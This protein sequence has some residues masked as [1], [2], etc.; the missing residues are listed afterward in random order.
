MNTIRSVL[1]S[2]TKYKEE[3]QKCSAIAKNNVAADKN[4]VT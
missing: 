4:I 1:P 3:K 2:S